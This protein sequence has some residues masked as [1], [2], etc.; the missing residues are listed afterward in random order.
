MPVAIAADVPNLP[1]FLFAHRVR[2]WDGPEPKGGAAGGS[3]SE[4]RELEGAR[5]QS[6]KSEL[7]SAACTSV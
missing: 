5:N 1:S 2:L 4:R 7:A 6:S 3:T